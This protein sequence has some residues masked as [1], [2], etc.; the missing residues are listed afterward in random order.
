MAVARMVM[1]TAGPC[2]R[3]RRDR[4]RLHGILMMSS[5]DATG[6]GNKQ[7]EPRSKAGIDPGA[8]STIM[9]MLTGAWAA[10]LVHTA[11]ELGIADHLA[12]GPRGV[13]FLAAQIGAHAESLARLLRALTAIGVVHE[14]KERSYGLTPLGVTLRSNVPGSMRAWVLLVFSDDQGTAWEALTHAV[15]TG[16]HGV[17]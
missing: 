15:R 6:E 7:V 17:G 10:R 11:A 16:E 3:M 8:A 1:R 4:R 13:D 12:D 2:L 9:S 5:S 14:S